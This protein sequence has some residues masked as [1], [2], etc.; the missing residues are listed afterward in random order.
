MLSFFFTKIYF[1]CFTVRA[2][3]EVIL[4]HAVPKVTAGVSASVP[5]VALEA[6]V[7]INNPGLIQDQEIVK[8]PSPVLH[9]M[10]NKDHKAGIQGQDQEVPGGVGR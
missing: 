5:L 8:C 1:S 4:L 2:E 10:K 6:G 7:M 3:A 9:I